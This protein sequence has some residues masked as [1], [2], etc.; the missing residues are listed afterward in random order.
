MIKEFLEEN[1]WAAKKATLS[2]L[3]TM[4][5]FQKGKKEIQVELCA[6]TSIKV[7]YMGD[8]RL[9]PDRSSMAKA[10]NKKEVDDMTVVRVFDQVLN[11][12]ISR[13]REAIHADVEDAFERHSRRHS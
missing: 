9:I 4:Y 1:G 11:T 13:H 5:L 7:T 2:G 3:S 12:L 8:T 10:L 6:D